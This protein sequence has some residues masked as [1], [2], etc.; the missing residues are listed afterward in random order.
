MNK[1]KNILFLILISVFFSCSKNKQQVSNCSQINPTFKNYDE[2]VNTV[3]STDFKITDDIDT[4]KSSWIRSAK[5]YSCNGIV[6]YL[7]FTTDENEY[8]HLNVPIEVWQEFKQADSFGKFYNQN[9]KLK[10]HLYTSD[11]E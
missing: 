1:M 4:S 5:Y 3:K 6:G 8:I 7:I 11:G 9:I 10:Y 2:A